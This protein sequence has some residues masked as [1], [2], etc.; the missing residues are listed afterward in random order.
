MEKLNMHKRA[1]LVHYAIRKG[2]LQLVGDEVM[3]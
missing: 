3:E 1:E 2:I